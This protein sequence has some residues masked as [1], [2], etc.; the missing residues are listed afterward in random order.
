MFRVRK[1]SLG[2]QIT[3]PPECCL[4][5]KRWW[6]AS[7]IL[8]CPL[9]TR[10]LIKAEMIERDRAMSGR[11]DRCSVGTKGVRGAEVLRIEE[12]G[13]RG[14]QGMDGW[15]EYRRTSLKE[16]CRVDIHCTRARMPPKG[17]DKE[18]H[19]HDQ[20]HLCTWVEMYLSDHLSCCAEDWIK[21]DRKDPG[22]SWYGSCE[23]PNK[24][25]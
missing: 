19:C 15:R 5:H 11:S 24:R 9:A 2:F 16:P 13:Q 18:M 3:D 12:K 21:G 1:H 14:S 4:C 25:N 7:S 20:I 8:C 6:D 10:S 17:T 22:D 23:Q